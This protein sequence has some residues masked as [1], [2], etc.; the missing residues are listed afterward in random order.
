MPV[1]CLKFLVHAAPGSQARVKPK[2]ARVWPAKP[3]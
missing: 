3:A 2:A 1:V